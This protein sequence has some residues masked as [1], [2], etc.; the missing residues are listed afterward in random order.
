MGVLVLAVVAL[1]SFTHLHALTNNPGIWWDEGTYIGRGIVVVRQHTLY[2]DSDAM[3]SNVAYYGTDYYGHPFLG[4]GILALV[5]ALVG[6]PGSLQGRPP[7]VDT[8][9]LYYLVPRTVMAVL[10]ILDTFLIYAVGR[11][12]F[13]RPRHGLAAAALFALSPVTRQMLYVQLDNFM[14]FWFLL[15]VHLAL[16]SQAR[17]VGRATLRYALL[18]GVAYG[19]AVLSK[20]PALYLL[21]VIPMILL[22]PPGPLAP[23]RPRAPKPAEDPHPPRVATVPLALWAAA[24]LATMSLWVIYALL[25]GEMDRLINGLDIFANRDPGGWDFTTLLGR[26]FAQVDP[27]LFAVGLAGLGYSLARLRPMVATW[28]ALYIFYL[29]IIPNRIQYYFL[30]LVVPFALLGGILLADIVVAIP[31]AVENLRRGRRTH[32]PAPIAAA[33]ATVLLAVVLLIPL[34]QIGAALDQERSGPRLQAVEW[35]IEHAPAHSIV[36]A[37]RAFLFLLQEQRPDLWSIHHVQA[38]TFRLEQMVTSG[39][40]GPTEVLVT[41]GQNRVV[42]QGAVP[43][44]GGT[45]LPAGTYRVRGFRNHVPVGEGDVSLD[46]DKALVFVIQGIRVVQLWDRHQAPSP[47]HHHLEVLSPTALPIS[48]IDDGV[49]TLPKGLQARAVPANLVFT[50]SNN[51]VGVYVYRLSP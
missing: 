23:R 22:L 43:S 41:D 27:F 46:R 34:S 26:F 6:Y 40:V 51:Y 44:G 28:A 9:A 19:A 24:A 33:V 17:E 3:E 37:N 30:P 20:L 35:I 7:G 10:T 14:T 4:W 42:F 25:Q 49:F 18:S 50:D 31:W 32:E 1:S 12:A 13:G 16:I 8:L 21:P 11:R 36:V 38:D 47:G 29:F 15:A 2:P 39:G 5:F 45:D 48:Y